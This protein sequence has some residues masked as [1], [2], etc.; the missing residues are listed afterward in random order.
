MQ[1]MVKKIYSFLCLSLAFVAIAVSQSSVKKPLTHSV[2]DSWKELAKPLISANGQ[3]V[4][5]EIN[6]QKG[7]GFLHLQN[8]LTG[9]HDSL[10]RGQEA[11]FSSSSDL[12][13]FKIKQPESLLR[14][15]K[16]AKTKKEDL[17]KDSLGI[18]ILAKD[19]VVKIPG[20]KSFQLP[21]DGGA[22]IAFLQ[23][24]PKEKP[25][26]KGETKDTLKLKAAKDSSLSKTIQEPKKEKEKKAKKGAFSEVETALLT[27]SNPL[28]GAKYIYENVTEFA[29][30]K[31][32][33]LCAFV[34]LKKDSVDSAAVHI[35]DTRILQAKKLFDS[36]GV[37]KKVLPDDAGR[38]VAYLFTKDTAKVK[39]YSLNLWDEKQIVP[40][41]VADTLSPGILKNWEVSENGK[42]SFSDDGSK[43]YFGTA[44]K[45]MPMPKDTLLDEEKTRVDIWNWQDG[46]LQ[47]QQLKELD[48]DLKQ[49]YSAVY[50]IPDKKVVQLADTLITRIKTIKKGNGELAIGFAEKPYEKLSSWEGASYRDVYLVDLKTGVKKLVAKKKSFPGDFSPDGKYIYWYEGEEKAWYCMDLVKL[51]PKCLTCQVPVAFYN[52]END[53]PSEPRPYG[54]AGWTKDDESLLVYDQYDIWQFDPRQAKTPLNITQSGRKEKTSYRYVNLDP[55]ALYIKSSEPILLKAVE[56]ESCKQGFA[57][58]KLNIPGSL[59]GLVRSDNDYSNPVKA[60]NAGQL[61]WQKSSYTVYPDLWT[62]KGDFADAKK[63]SV[64]NPQQGQYLWGTVEQLKWTTL[65][66]KEMKGLLYKP[67]NFDP[68]RKYPM[69]IYY[70]ERYSDKLNSHYVPS[71]SRSTVNFPYYNSNGYLVFVPDITYTTGHPGKAAYNSI[72]GGTLELIKRPYVDAANMGLQGQSWGG[73]QTAYMVTQTG[74]FKAAMAGAPVSNMT[75]AYGGI[76]WESGVVRTFQYEHGQSRIG[77]NLWE[78]RDLYIENSP[79]FFADRI[80]TPLLIMSN[81]NDGAVPWYQGIEFFNALRRLGKPAWLL[82]YNGEEHNLT[83]RPNRQDLG[84]RMSQFFDHYLKGGAEPKWMKEGIPAVLKG[85]ESGYGE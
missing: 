31:N 68:A 59:T 73:Y 57:T 27:I 78:K 33:A 53:T 4:E 35:F 47:S 62:S 14:K 15:L 16:L 61:I 9:R 10:P 34:T 30:S 66:G 85:K 37:A 25:K 36:N 24:L 19:S 7:D 74:M 2:Y 60:K 50:R 56:E 29:F 64:V 8:L 21:K 44:P 38:Q 79:I 71:P 67:E 39:R 6:P 17:P 28:T 5:Y 1:V 52:E 18:R 63:L 54:I 22:W 72:M 11:L 65:E 45:I 32:G 84:I 80:T 12:L 20:L 40:R 13:V 58:L 83:K 3:W 75:S 51:Q 82:V 23:D 77:G 76:R 46:R 26:A 49:S 43:L 41:V 70:Y 48:N 69:I 55:E 81:D 42:L